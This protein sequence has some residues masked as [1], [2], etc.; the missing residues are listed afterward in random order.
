MIWKDYGSSK[1]QG[2]HENSKIH[3]ALAQ[4]YVGSNRC[5]ERLL[6]GEMFPWCSIYESSIMM[7]SIIYSAGTATDSPIVLVHFYFCV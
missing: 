6:S 1:A 3:K 4:G 5:L 2:A 7:G